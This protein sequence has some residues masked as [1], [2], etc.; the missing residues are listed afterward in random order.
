MRYLL[1]KVDY[2]RIAGDNK[3]MQSAQLNIN[4]KEV[5]LFILAAL[6]YII[7]IQYVGQVNEALADERIWND[8]TEV[9]PQ[10]GKL[11][12]VYWKGECARLAKWNPEY[13]SFETATE[14]LH[15]RYWMYDA[16]K[17]RETIVEYCVYGGE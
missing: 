15:I 4:W 8:I 2:K 10:P 3:I 14:Q 12:W 9:T 6:I 5:S 17:S 11:T 16:N 7:F 13:N 1:T